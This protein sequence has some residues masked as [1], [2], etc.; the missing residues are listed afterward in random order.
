MSARMS[1]TRRGGGSGAVDAGEALRIVLTRMGHKAPNKVQLAAVKAAV[2][3]P[4]SNLLVVAPTGSGKTAIGY[5][6]L[7]MHGR[8]FYLAP[9]RSI[10]Y[11][12]YW[13]LKKVFP[14]KD[15]VITNKDYSVPRSRIK[16]ADIRVMS[17]YKFMLYADMLEPGD[18]VVVVDEIHK[19]SEDPDMEAAVTLM[20]DKGFRVIGLSATIAEEDKPIVS[21][22]LNAI[23]VEGDKRPV[24]LRHVEV[25]AELTPGGLAVVDGG[26]YLRA[27]AHYVSRYELVADL[28]AGILRREPDAGI[29]VWNPVRKEANTFAYHIAQR[30]PPAPPLEVSVS[31]GSEHDRVLAAVIKRRVGIHHGGISPA[32]LELVMELFKKRELKVVVT[33]YTLSHGVNLP[34]RYVVITTLIDHSLNPLDP[35]TFHQVAGRAG[36]PGLDPYGEAIT[37]TVG[38]LEHRLYKKA[39]AM[40]AGRIRSVLHREWTITKIAAQ[41]LYYST[42]DSLARFLRRT[43]YVAKLGEEGLRTLAKL[44]EEAAALVAEYYYEVDG[45]VFKPRGREEAIAAKMGLHPYEWEV[46]KTAVSGDYKATV[47]EAVMV[48][49][50]ALELNAKPDDMDTVVRYGMLAIYLGR[51]AAR[52]LA[53]MTQTILD[54]AAV[55]ARRVYGWR[56][57][58]FANARRIADAFVYAGNPSLE[59]LARLLRHDEMKR[60][61]RHMPYLVDGKYETPGPEIV[62]AN[63]VELVFGVKKRIYM[64]RVRAVAA[65]LAEALDLDE[66][67]RRALVAAAE[68][69]ARRVARRSGARIVP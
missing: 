56:S 17:P 54:A 24:P 45:E 5:A 69:E 34:A 64:R 52:Q 35:S 10:M 65:A 63:M 59:Q 8:G 14:D 57:Q 30:M 37:L 29:L 58:E 48:A 15:I 49:D 66:A 28:V 33:C 2:A 67:G 51:N 60:L 61:I 6:L 4:D 13:E 46:A 11:E 41:R 25:R 19:V 43:L 26:G 47:E 1:S 27:G 18:G 16:S 23:L 22:W 50:K 36:R 7:A 62:A 39:L 3:N 42:A 68:Q 12:K 55:Y 38:E 44:A 20:L 31:R 53:E 40:G 32:N 21:R 9:L